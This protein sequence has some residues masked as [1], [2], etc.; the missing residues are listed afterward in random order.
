MS[1]II[2]L[3]YGLSLY[4]GHVP[5]MKF[6]Y[7]ETYG[8]A[9]TKYFQDYRAAT[10]HSSRTNYHRGG[11]FPSFY[12]YNPD[13]AIGARTRSR[14]RWLSAPRYS[15]TNVDH[16]RKEELIK[17][18]RMSSAQREYYKDKSATVQKVEHF[19]LPQKADQQFKKELAQ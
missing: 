12:S 5:T 14:D 6:D 8:N 1:A 9:T 16:D 19:Q 2:Y 13:M 11:Y 18:D 15:L 3:V 17:F 7:A 4:K 10:L